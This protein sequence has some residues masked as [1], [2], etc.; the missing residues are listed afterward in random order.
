MK[1]VPKLLTTTFM[2]LALTFASCDKDSLEGPI[3]PQGPPGE[4]G[5]QGP[6][7]PA[8][9]DGEALGVP[10]PQGEQGPA[11]PAGE[12][13]QDG[14]AN[15]IASDWFPTQFS[16]SPTT[17]TSFSVPMTELTDEMAN[18]ALIMAYGKRLVN[19]GSTERIYL[20]PVTIGER[21]YQFYAED[22]EGDGSYDFVCQGTSGSGN[23]LV[24]STFV[25]IR[26]VIVPQ[27]TLSGKTGMQDIL[28]M[29]YR[30]AME[31]LGLDY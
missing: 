7:G 16:S 24:F 2:S 9:E 31:Y 11:G 18:S 19:G 29:E 12:D 17:L 6:P 23:N 22:E 20:L 10:G 27:D 1:T 30:E 13:G 28:K 3:G 5:I 8:G 21:T 25:E 4:Q 15:V 26:Y 14:N